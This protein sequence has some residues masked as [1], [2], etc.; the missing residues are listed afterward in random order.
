MY[1]IHRGGALGKEKIQV[2]QISVIILA[3]WRTPHAK[4]AR[5]MSQRPAHVHLES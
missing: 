2:K 5:E 1:V 4:N 3:T